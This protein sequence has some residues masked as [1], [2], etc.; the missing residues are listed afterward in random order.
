[1][2]GGIT[3]RGRSFSAEDIEFIRKVIAEYGVEG[4]TRISRRLCLAWGWLQANGNTKDM[5][6]REA[7]QRLEAMGEIELPRPLKRGRG[8]LLR[9]VVREEPQ[10]F[11]PRSVEAS[12]ADVG[13]IEMRMVRGSGEERLY[14]ELVERHHYLGYRQIVGEHLKYMA[15]CRQGPLACLG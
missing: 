13:P 10:L 4:R 1:M 3:I 2:E 11:V 6:C 12:L 8:A 14:R 5:A 7:L 9:K 15:F